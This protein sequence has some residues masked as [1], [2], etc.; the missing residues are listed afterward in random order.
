MRRLVR[1]FRYGWSAGCRTLGL[2][3]SGFRANLKHHL[4][5]VAK[6]PDSTPFSHSEKS[7]CLYRRISADPAAK[8]NQIVH[9]GWPILRA[10]CEGWVLPFDP[11]SAPG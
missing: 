10:V 2:E 4:W 3:G 5:R 9:G 6:I 1:L 7:D 11:V 8:S